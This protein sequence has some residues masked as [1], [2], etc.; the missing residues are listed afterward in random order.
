M[1]TVK[2]TFYDFADTTKADSEKWKSFRRDTMH[3]TM[4]SYGPIGAL[5]DPDPL[6]WFWQSGWRSWT[7]LWFMGFW[8]LPQFEEYFISDSQKS[9]SEFKTTFSSSDV[10]LWFWTN[11]CKTSD[12]KLV[13]WWLYS[14]IYG[15]CFGT[16]NCN[17]VLGSEFILQF[18]TLC[19]K[20]RIYAYVMF[21]F[22]KF[23]LR[24][25]LV[26]FFS[27]ST[28]LPESTVIFH[29]ISW[30]WFSWHCD[31]HCAR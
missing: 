19:W 31:L 5:T 17:L 21:I 28:Q 22:V 18:P 30:R 11:R 20:K 23:F 26:L 29:T 27:C 6:N 9:F 4:K 15:H 10:S 3:Q 14:W 2:E 24:S 12:C 16:R 25:M 1:P 8:K 7:W 13:T